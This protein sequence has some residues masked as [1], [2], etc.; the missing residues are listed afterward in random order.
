MAWSLL[1][2]WFL[3][4]KGI[5][6]PLSESIL[7]SLSTSLVRYLLNGIPMSCY[8]VIPHLAPCVIWLW[9]FSKP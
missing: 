4:N 6:R 7:D 3:V 8:L 5:I 2:G 9:T 1:I